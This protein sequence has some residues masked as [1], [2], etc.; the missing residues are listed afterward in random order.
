[1][2]NIQ[3][4]VYNETVY[5]IEVN[6]RSSRTVPYISK[7]TGIPAIALATRAMLGERLADMG[8]GTGLYRHSGYYAI[9]M[10]VFSFEKI[11]GAD[12]SLGPEMKSTGEVLGISRSY[13][14]ALLKAFDGAGVH[15][16]KDGKIIVTV[17]DK[18][19]AEICE[20]FKNMKDMQF[21]LYATPGTRKALMAA[22][23]PAEPINKIS[24]DSPNIH[25]MLAAE[26]V[27][28]I[29][30]TPTHG[31][32]ENRDGFKLRRLAVEAGCSC[33]TS[34]DAAKAIMESTRIV[35][36]DTVNLTDIA[37]L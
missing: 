2:M 3:F 31:R 9:K 25:D 7:V 37:T 36:A 24:G 26:D 30:N 20:M 1:M 16:P 6:P 28:L 32:L 19:K 27:S 35:E 17:R 23:V 5:I 15:L 29:I 22:G 13:D 10:P 33:L 21:R 8:Y 12:T 34:L 18:D 11:L 4:I 14:E